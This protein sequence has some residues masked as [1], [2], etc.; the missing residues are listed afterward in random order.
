MY[1]NQIDD[2]IDKI[3]DQLYLE[4]LVKD[5]AFQ[6]IVEGKKI[7]YVEYRE[8]INK[9]IQKFMDSIDISPIQKLI[10][11]KE[12]LLRILDIIKRYVAYYYFLSIAYYYTGTIKDFRNNLIQYSKLQE[13]S[14][15]TVKNFFDTENNYQIIYFYRI[16]KD[17][18]N[19]LL[20][21]EL[22]KKTLNPLG[23]KDAIDFLNNL[24]KN[25]VDNYLL[26]VVQEDGEERVAINVHNL[27]KTIVFREIYRNQE[28]AMV[29]GILND[30]EETQTEYTYIDIV[31]TSD[32]VVDFDSFRQMFMGEEYTDVLARDLYELANESARIPPSVNIETKNNNLLELKIITP[33]VDD[34]LRYHRDT[35]RLDAEADKTFPFPLVSTN[36]AKNIQQLLLYQQRKKKENTKAQLIVTKIDAIS[37]YY[38]ENVRNNPEVLNDIKKYFQNPFSYRKAVIHN[39][40]EE[41]HVLNKIFNQGRKAIEGNEYYL[42]L[43]QIVQNAYF[44]FRDFQKYGATLT[45]YPEQPINM[46]RY[47][48]IEY[49]NQM[50][51]LEVDMHTGKEDEMINLVGLA[52]GPFGDGPIQCVRKADMVDIRGIKISYHKNGM[53]VTKGTDNGYKAFRKIIKHFFINTITISPGP[54]F[55]LYNDYSDIRDLN[56][57]TFNK[58]IYWIYDPTKDEFEMDIYENL[59]TDSSQEIIKFMNSLIYDDIIKYLER[60]LVNLI[61]NNTNL[62]SF[63][64]Q[65]LLEWFSNKNRLFLKQDDKRE[66]FINEYLRKKE[67]VPSQIIPADTMEPIEKPKFHS[68]EKITMFR[69]KIDM[70]NPIRP[71]PYVKLEA[72]TK[73]ARE[74]SIISQV[75]SKC[76]H[77]ME[78]NELIKMKRE[79]LNAYNMAITQFIEKFAIETLQLDFICKICGQLLPLKQ[80]TQDGNFDN[81]TQKFVTAYTPLDIPLEDIKEYNK[82]KLTIRYLDKFINRM[83]LITGTNM[84]VGPNL[85]IKQ[86]RKALVKNIIDLLVKHNSV[87]LRKNQN[88]EERLDFFSKK[89]NINKDLDVLFFFEPDDNIINFDPNSPDIKL[90]R[91][92]YNNILLYFILIFITELNGTQITT[93]YFD[94][95]ANIFVFLKYGVKLFDN[96]LIKKNISDMETAPITD[97]PVLC[98]LIYLMGY[99]MFKYRLWYH[100][101]ADTKQF[102]PYYLKIIINSIVDLFNSISIEAGKMPNDYVYLLT[103]QKLYGQLYTTFKDNFVINVLKRYHYRFS[104]KPVAD[105]VSVV[106]EDLVKMYSIEN[107]IKIVLPT[108]KLSAFKISDGVS[109]NVDDHIL[110]PYLAT[111][112]DITNCPYGSYHYW[113]SKGKNIQCLFC[114]EKGEDVKGNINRSTEAYYYELNKIANRHCLEGTYHDFDRGVCMVCGRKYN[115]IFTYSDRYLLAD[116]IQNKGNVGF[117]L[118]KFRTSIQQMYNMEDLNKLEENLD[119]IEDKNIKQVLE[120]RTKQKEEEEQLE[121]LWKTS[122]DDLVTD[123]RKETGD[124]M[125]GQTAMMVNKLIDILENEIGVYTDLDIN[126]YP[127]FLRENVY[128]INHSYDGV[129]LNEPIIL[130]EKDAR[131]NFRENHP[132]FKVDVYYYTDHK[133]QSD[134]F[135]DAVSLKLLGYKEKHKDYV[136][137]NR[138]NAYLLINPSIKNRLLTIGYSTKYIDIGDV[139]DKNSKTIP[140]ANQNYFQILDSLIIDHIYK[141]K[142]IVDKISSILYKIKNF[143]PA[144]EQEEEVLSLQS[145]QTIDTLISKYARLLKDIK[146]SDD[147]KAFDDWNNLRNMFVYE[148]INWLETNV[149]ATGNMYV[150]SDLINYYDVSSSLMFYYL[151]N[152]LISII[153]S[154]LEKITK[155]NIAQMYIEIINYIYN[156]YNIDPYKNSHE[157]KRFEYILNGSEFMVDILKKGQG[158]QQSKE[159][160]EELSEPE[161]TDLENVSEEEKEEID[162]LKEEAEALDVEADYYAEEDEDYAQEGDMEE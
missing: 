139:F 73:E 102:N 107:P 143:V 45:M 96:L 129:P 131:M 32:D 75:E 150:N 20:M 147:G 14:T 24:G 120:I 18:S 142:A 99:F 94:K 28:Q 81:N 110:Y 140:D 98:Y 76:Q 159:L 36:N 109:Y 65:T 47:S 67:L 91:L 79:S 53:V 9:F 41:V 83:S 50:S 138:P 80:Y 1:V 27:I 123:Y 162:D 13:N 111:I 119:N 60:K 26:M 11:N 62:S 59:R 152:K 126:K 133:N 137:V 92:K 46:L 118:E 12:N 90:N 52:I 4:G 160:E 17:V 25:F 40:L 101:A 29:F 128:V 31:V 34:F 141:T 151:I 55:Y 44:N 112:T 155:T 130:T 78:W 154:N 95:I 87:N 146:L 122:F 115:E 39:H 158:L 153:D 3:L 30:I 100:P 10:N 6:L 69:I 134:V 89:F 7:N 132:F 88:T 108:R 85:A 61:N 2:I 125:Y 161:L 56:P 70:T 21:T 121:N 104:D 19:L 37:D 51:Y 127:V 15:F 57:E 106:Q 103:S 63:Q 113:T 93:M 77:E 16:I 66:L 148:P 64:I 33:I 71:R 68:T 149:R 5:E 144:T 22:Q 8:K 72:Y 116:A 156:L 97:Y 82:Y 145:T 23:I 49:Q 38:S 136:L 117:Y 105:Q 35:G 157:L 43:R 135:Y 42:S 54:P 74:V 86:H 58:I 48:N 84:L 114:E 124:K